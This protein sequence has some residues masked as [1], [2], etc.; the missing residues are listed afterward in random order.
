[1]YTGVDLHER[2]EGQLRCLVQ[3]YFVLPRLPAISRLLPMSTFVVADS[4]IAL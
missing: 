2:V 4:M 1:M 3:T